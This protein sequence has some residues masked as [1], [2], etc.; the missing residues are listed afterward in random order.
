MG[1]QW[2]L[3]TLGLATLPPNGEPTNL[4]TDNQ[5]LT[6]ANLQNDAIY[7]MKNIFESNELDHGAT[8]HKIRTVRT[9][10]GRRVKIELADLK[11]Q[12]VTSKIEEAA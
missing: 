8:V 3:A 5:Q 6:L 10:S 1:L 9:G 12:N 7:G 2:Q 4:S 11:S